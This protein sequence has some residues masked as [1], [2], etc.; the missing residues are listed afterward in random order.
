MRT[1]V[2]K[3]RSVG[4]DLIN[5]GE[6]GRRHYATYIRERLTGFA[7]ESVPYPLPRDQRAFPEFEAYL[8]SRGVHRPGGPPCIGPVSWRDFAAVTRDIENLR[9]AAGGCEGVFMTSVSPGQAARIMKNRYYRTEEEY[10]RALAA[11]LRDE[12]RAIVEAGFILQ[13]DC[14]D[15][16]SGWNNLPDEVGVAEFLSTAELHIAIL[17]DA[18]HDLPPERMRL[19]V[20]WGNYE[21]PHTHDIEL[22]EILELVLTARPAG[23]VLEGANPRHAHEWQVLRQTRWPRDKIL[24]P[25]VIDTTT[26]FVEHPRLIAERLVR[27]AE[28]A[29]RERIIAGTDCGFASTGSSTVLPSVA[30]AKLAAL[31]EGARLASQEL[32]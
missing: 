14:P 1:V 13:L 26:N 9:A 25:G 17:N 19:H 32:G 27:Y 12:Y 3:Q 2:Q 29:G 28:A 11:V 24:I 23:L 18:I 20:C 10:L 31:V 7:D 15:L 6:Q 4:L 22:H 16:A 8:R 21:G 5:D 30:W